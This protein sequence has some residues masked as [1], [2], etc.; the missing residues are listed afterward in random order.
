MCHL[1]IRLALAWR[2][3]LHR[4]IWR[5]ASI[6]QFESILA[7]RLASAAV[8]TAIGV[9]LKFAGAPQRMPL[10]S[11]AIDAMLTLA[12]FADPR[13]SSR[14]LHL[15]RRREG[16]AV[17]TLVVDA[18]TAGQMVARESKLGERVNY[19]VVGFL[20]DDRS[21]IGQ[22]L[23]GCRVLAKVDSLPSVVSDLGITEVILDM[24]SDRGA[25]IRRIGELAS[26]VG[27]RTRTVPDTTD[28]GSGRIEYSALRPVEV[29]DLLR[30]PPIQT[31]ISKVQVLAN[32]RTVIVSGA[33]GS[34]GSELY[35]QIVVF[36]PQLLVVL[37][38]SES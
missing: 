30:R 19:E 23:Q 12:I 38:H 1:P 32:A 26:S 22:I 5:F 2:A 18:G 37:D 8:T 20:D 17:R 9:G 10:S 13:L 24:P 31:H 27:A 36:E 33:G 25:E 11:I 35:R 15:R 14:F 4:C 16:N 28:I 7:V 29:K 21:K 3:S 34:I 6:E